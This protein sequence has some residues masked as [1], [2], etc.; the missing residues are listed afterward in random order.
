M[1]ETKISILTALQVALKRIIL[2]SITRSQRMIGTA[3]VS[4]VKGTSSIP[5]MATIAEKSLQELRQL[6]ITQM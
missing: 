4:W 1:K 5:D 2:N 6:K 3:T